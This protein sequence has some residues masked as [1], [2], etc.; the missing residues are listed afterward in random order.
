[1]WNEPQL[2]LYCC[3]SPGAKD[4]SAVWYGV[5]RKSFYVRCMVTEVDIPKGEMVSESSVREME[6]IKRHFL[7]I[8]KKNTGG[9]KDEKKVAQKDKNS[10]ANSF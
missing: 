9:F 3:D 1:M 7:K 2:D 8:R 6:M 4:L 10:V 5:A